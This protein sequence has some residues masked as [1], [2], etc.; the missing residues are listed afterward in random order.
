[1]DLGSSWDVG[2]RGAEVGFCWS[3]LAVLHSLACLASALPCCES[4]SVTSGEIQRGPVGGALQE[5]LGVGRRWAEGASSLGRGPYTCL[6]LPSLAGQ[7]AA[8]GQTLG[9]E[10]RGRRRP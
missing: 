4:L 9:P 10:Q 8:P 3:A 5:S 7:T 1:M 6:H 2:R